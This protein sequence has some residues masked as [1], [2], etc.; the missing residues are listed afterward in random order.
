MVI[1]RERSLVRKEKGAGQGA[2]RV[3]M[4]KGGTEKEKKHDQRRVNGE[5]GLLRYFL[6]C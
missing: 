5:T 3:E 2:E 6:I 4:G 1:G